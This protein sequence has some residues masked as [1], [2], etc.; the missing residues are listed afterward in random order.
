MRASTLIQKTLRVP[1]VDGPTGDGS[2]VARQL[3]A[4]LLSV[5]FTA[6]GEL[7]THLSGLE[8]GLA[9]DTAAETV[10]A[11]RELV[12]D[13]VRHNTYF[14]DF[15]HNV[16][17][18]VE[19][20]TQCLIDTFGPEWTDPGED[21]DLLTL[22]TYGRYQHTH[23]EM[24]ARRTELL[25][26]VRDRVT[27]LHLGGSLADET[28]RLYRTLAGSPTPLSETNLTLLGELAAECADGEQPA[29][30]PVRENRALINTV[31]L[32]RGQPLLVDTVTDVLR[33]A[34]AVSDGDV[35]LE[36]P[37]RFRSFRR[38]ERRALLGALDQVIAASPAKLA[39]VGR[40]TEPWKRLGERLHPHEHPRFAHA[41]DVFAVARGD[42]TV[43]TTASRI[44]Q[45]FSDGDLT[46]AVELLA[47]TPGLLLRN[48]D[49]VLREAT[50][51]ET[52]TTL[53]AVRDVLG[54]VSGRVILSLREHLLNR[55]EP[56]SARIFVNKWGRA[57][58]TADE[59]NP[60][61]PTVV[62]RLAELLDDELARRLPSVDRLV[63]DPAVL[64]IAVPLSGKGHPNGIG[65]VPRGSWTPVDG[66][67][68][69]FFVHWRQRSQRTDFDLSVVLLDDDFQFAGQVSWTMLED[70]DITHS[71]DVTSAADGAS[72]FINVAL[73][74]VTAR[75]VLPQVN[76]YAGEPFADVAE[77]FF[78]FMT[79]DAEQ[80][81]AP[82][83]PRTVRM[84]SDLRGTGRVAL[85]LVFARDE[86]GAWSA[87]WLHLF[88]NGEAR[89]N[90]VEANATSTSLLAKTVLEHQ[91][92]TMA[93]LARL[94]RAKAGSYTPYHRGIELDGPV[95]FVGLDR[96]DGLPEGSDVYPVG[97]WSELI[98]E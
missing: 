5:G 1:A 13:H 56:D 96:P 40:Y 16:P 79:R 9:M 8:F 33:V 72:E 88:L 64:D 77:S 85:P 45:A 11:V 87:T 46:A 58:A 63:V 73:S 84:K 30:I 39:D 37:T 36:T 67:L 80:A 60:L 66:E 95:T 23:A 90:R 59:R 78:G 7:L 53:A 75:Y 97:R 26:S 32:D 81:G 18:T 3:D 35:T 38:P 74:S 65:V 34:C 2:A 12:G 20:W 19:F 91:Y 68:L 54:D 55:T 51:A 83:E 98:P 27:V 89:F 69:R 76:V 47:R 43:R 49:R 31:L 25:P 52:D 28:Q 94:L 21:V 10:G 86:A 82:F 48:V 57:W 22:P 44:E 17:D 41:Q 70:D 15:P 50:P 42:R 71:G 4:A 61:A 93:H 29:A 62:A 6:S 92:L 14:I 24:L